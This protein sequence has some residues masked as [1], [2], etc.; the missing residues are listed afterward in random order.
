M[1][2]KEGKYEWDNIGPYVSFE[3]FEGEGLYICA[4]NRKKGKGEFIKLKKAEV[5][6]WYKIRMEFD[7]SESKEYWVYIDGKY[8]GKGY[9]LVDKVNYIEL[10]AFSNTTCRKG[11][12]DNILLLGQ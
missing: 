11:Y 7:L 10:C 9:V 12:V 6:R 1:C 8:A 3:Y 5:G 2:F 4:Y